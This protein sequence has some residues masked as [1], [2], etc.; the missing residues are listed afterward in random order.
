MKTLSLYLTAALL[1][2]VF[3]CRGQETTNSPSKTSGDYSLFNPVPGDQLRPLSSE[4]YDGVPDARTVDAGHVQVESGFINYYFN[5][6]TPYHYSSDEFLWE[7]RITV[8]LLNHVDIFIR[9]SYEIRSYNGKDSSSE[10]GRITTGLKINLWGDDD[11]A[12]ALAIRPYVSIPTSDDDGDVD[13]GGD[14]A[15]LVRLSHGFYVKLDSEFYEAHNNNNTLFAGFDN[16]MSINK[17]LCSKA[18]AYWYL[19]STVT[20]DSSQQWY[21]YTG[22]G[23]KYNFTK[24]L[25]IFTG[26]GFGLTSSA[27][28][29]NPRFGFV[30]RF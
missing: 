23:L 12:T 28:D 7:P 8:G 1:A 24:N 2:A 4:V 20:S 25:Q 9:P 29:Y 5:S 13:G 15:L 27:Y 3:P 17:S 10:F 26:I 14:V 21:G 19:D 6:V 22:F 11:G 18:E 30:W 16:S